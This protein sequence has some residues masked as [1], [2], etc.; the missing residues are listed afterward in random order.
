MVE[1]SKLCMPGPQD[2]IFQHPFAPE[3]SSEG[4]I[5][6]LP[7]MFIKR[8]NTLIN[9][10]K[11]HGWGIKTLRARS[12]GLH[13]PTP[14]CAWGR[15]WGWHQK[16]PTM[17]IQRAIMLNNFPKIQGWGIKTV[18]ARASGLHF[19]TPFWA[20]GWPRGWYTKSDLTMLLTHVLLTS[21]PKIIFLGLVVSEEIAKKIIL[22][23]VFYYK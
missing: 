5:R 8:A 9:L 19:P 7:I 16:M 6:K 22:F 1:A 18:H 12:S 3:V 10:P 23:R 20:W 15:P 14:F 17:F 11:I 2:S 4:G 13:F 21:Y